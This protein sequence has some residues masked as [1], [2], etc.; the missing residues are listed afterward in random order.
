MGNNSTGTRSASNNVAIGYGALEQDS[1]GNNNIAIG[2]NAGQNIE[3]GA[4]NIFIG[5][6]AAQNI[7][8]TASDILYIENSSS[9]TPLIYGNFSKDSLGFN[10]SISATL[11]SSNSRVIQFIM[12]NLHIYSHMTLLVLLVMI[13]VISIELVDLY[14]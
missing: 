14:T 11:D 13:V 5:Y 8:S 9:T 3:S 6:Y 10:G 7:D 4:N 1:T 2:R 12:I